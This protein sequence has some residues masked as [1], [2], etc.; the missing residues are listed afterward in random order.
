MNAAE[1]IWQQ[2]GILRHSQILLD[3]YRRWVGSE[4]MDRSGTAAEQAQRLADL[5]SVVAS[6]GMQADPIFNYANRKAL[7]MFEMTWDE[8]TR[9]PSRYSAEPL[10]RDERERLMQEVRKNHC[11]RNYRGVRISKNGRRFRVEDATIWNLFDEEGQPC[12]MG[13]VLFR[14]TFL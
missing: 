10:E 13:A 4:L 11:V 2:P 14:W 6:H 9:L 8:F 5:S 7:E 1:N 12:G 3:S